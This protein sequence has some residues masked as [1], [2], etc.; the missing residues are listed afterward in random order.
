MN[1]VTV[2]TNEIVNPRH[3]STTFTRTGDEFRIT[4]DRCYDDH[5]DLDAD[6]PE[7]RVISGRLVGEHLACIE[8]VVFAEPPAE[9]DS[10]RQIDH[11]AIISSIFHHVLTH[12]TAAT[13]YM[14]HDNLVG[15]EVSTMLYDQ[16]HGDLMTLVAQSRGITHSPKKS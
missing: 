13:A 11:T 2:E 7:G 10:V 5:S 8:K 9:K 3:Y 6:L 1:P 15:G 12:N 14:R 4:I 16:S